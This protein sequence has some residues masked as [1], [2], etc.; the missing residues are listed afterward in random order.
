[1]NVV[2]LFLLC[3]H[4]F[5]NCQIPGFRSQICHNINLLEKNLAKIEINYN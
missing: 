5:K 3:V 1:M 4:F 2:N